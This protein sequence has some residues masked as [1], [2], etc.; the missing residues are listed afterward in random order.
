[1]QLMR[2]LVLLLAVVALACGGNT[3]PAV[4]ATGVSIEDIDKDPMVL[5]PSSPLAI[6]TL[7]ARALADDRTLGKPM[8][9]LAD[10][11]VPL[12]EESGFS[13]SRDVDRITVGSYSLEGVD[14]AGVLMGKFDADKIQLAAKNHTPT[15]SGGPIVE[16]KYADHSIY[17]VA[18][19][20]FVVISPKT[21][22]FGTDTAIRRSLDRLKSG[23]LKRD[24]QP[25]IYETLET[26]GA[27]FAVASDLSTQPNLSQMSLGPVSLGFTKGLSVIRAVGN[28]ANGQVNVAG[29]ATWADEAGA[30]G[31][32]DAFRGLVKLATP[33]TAMGFIPQLQNLKIEPVKNDV[34]VSFT[35]DGS[36]LASVLGKVVQQL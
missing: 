23:T 11:L 8:A 24:M 3:P 17:A 29:T 6:M 4:T 9:A 19:T 7:D 21:V 33:F 28:T 16:T 1:M 2:S 27:A 18:N 36:Q 15:K 14:F 22:V 34:Q 31:G 26:K 35:V 30:K 12:G 25:W 5:L 32:A 13:P 10:K 20:G